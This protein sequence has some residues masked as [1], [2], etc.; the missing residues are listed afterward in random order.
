ML[1]G[2]QIT[3]CWLV[4][5]TSQNQ[6]IVRMTDFSLDVDAGLSSPFLHDPG[7]HVTNLRLQAGGTPPQVDM[8]LP[9]SDDGPIFAD[10]VRRGVWRGGAVRLWLC[11]YTH[12]IERQ[13]LLVD[14]KIGNVQFTDDLITSVEFLGRGDSTA[15]IVLPRVQPQC[16]HV[17][18]DNYCTF[19][20][21]TVTLQAEVT[22][23]IDNGRFVVSFGRTTSL[24]F[25]DGAVRFSSGL[26]AGVSADVR[27]WTS[28]LAL[29]ELWDPMPLAVQ[30]GDQLEIHAGCQKTRAA[31]AAYNNINHFGGY[32]H[33]PGATY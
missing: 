23:V 32:D 17:F 30:A 9:I 16:R 26:N 2:E 1:A 15:D 22:D 18:G 24:D 12:P 14:A 27:R 20:V 19:A 5:M 21:F 31:C 33:V 3:C 25:T 6:Q 4:E 10:H 28:D 7:F 8:Q 29:V 13:A 11:D